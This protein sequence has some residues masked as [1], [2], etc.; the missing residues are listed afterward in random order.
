MLCYGHSW[1]VGAGGISN[2]KVG[3]TLEATV[4]K[5]TALKMGVTPVA[6]DASCVSNDTSCRRVLSCGLCLVLLMLLT[7]LLH[8]TVAGPAS[9]ANCGR[10]Y[11]CVVLYSC[12]KCQGA[13]A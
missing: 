6:A 8:L 10:Q 5:R 11:R 9:W 7:H 2:S 13:L 1:C 12:T 4:L 3:S